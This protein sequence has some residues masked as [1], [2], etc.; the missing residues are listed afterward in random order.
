[1]KIRLA[2]LAA[3]AACAAA[4]PGFAEETTYCNAFITALPYTITTQG[5]YCF[6]RN[7]STSI[8][9]G[10]AITI[11]ADFV[12]LDLNNFKLG[13]GAAGTATNAIGVRSVDRDN[14]TVRNGNIRGFAVGI[15][16]EGTGTQAENLLVEKNVLDG[17]YKA[18][19]AVKGR[20]VVVRENV[21]TNTGG[22][23]SPNTFC[24]G[25]WIGIV[26][27]GSFCGEPTPMLAERNVVM[28]TPAGFAAAIWAMSGGLAVENKVVG[29][30]STQNAVVAT[31]CRDNSVVMATGPGFS[32]SNMVG[33]NSDN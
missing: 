23:T 6:N 7:L 4:V 22:S 30:A 2:V 10:A 27:R 15:A 26:D 17:N 20:N 16:L 8:T 5:H 19:I 9:T 33:I 14:V 29:S 32:C 13:G 25:W 28:S 12:W 24:G 18:G 1:M 21:V 31:T 11:N 3:L